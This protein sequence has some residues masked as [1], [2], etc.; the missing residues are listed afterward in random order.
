MPPSRVEG[1]EPNLAALDPCLSTLDASAAKQIPVP[2]LTDA[3]FPWGGVRAIN[4]QFCFTTMFP[5][6]FRDGAGRSSANR[7][8]VFF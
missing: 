8:S 6:R 2:R 5:D 4:S 1:Q 7:R 3:D